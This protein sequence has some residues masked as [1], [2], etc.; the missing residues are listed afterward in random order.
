MLTY[1]YLFINIYTE[2]EQKLAD[3]LAEEV[4]RLQALLEHQKDRDAKEHAEILD[5]SEK[6]F[7]FF[8]IVYTL[9]V[10][11]SAANYNLISKA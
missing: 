10:H 2:L 9:S 1:L 8:L 6:S 7:F 5:V 11:T 4:T 3:H